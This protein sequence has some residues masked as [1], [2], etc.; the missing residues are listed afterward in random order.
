MKKIFVFLLI[1][2]FLVSGCTFNVDVLTPAPTVT[3]SGSSQLTPYTT[4]IAASPIATI[5][6]TAGP[7]STPPTATPTSPTFY[8]VFFKADPGIS[9]DG[10]T[11]PGGTKRVFAVWNYLNMRP[12][13]NVKREWYLNGQ[14][15]LTREEAWDFAKYDANGA[16]QDI[17]IYDF[18][19][20]L[21]TGI[22]E[23][24][25]YIDNVIQYIGTSDNGQP[26][27]KAR[28]EIRL[29]DEAQAGFASPDFQWQVEIF[30]ERRIVLEDKTRNPTTIYTAREVPY[31]S[32]F[33]DS[34]HFLFVDRDRS[35]QKPGTTIG[36]R[37]DLWVVDVP[38]GTT[39]LLYKSDTSFAGIGGP[40]PSPY[41]HYIA[42]LEGSRFGDA[43]SVDKRMIFFELSSDFSSA[44]VI[45][46][47]EFSGLPA[48]TNG[49]IYPN[50][51]VLVWYKDSTYIVTM[52]GTCDADKSKLGAYIFNLAD[53]TANKVISV[54]Q[55]PIPGDLGVGMIHGT[56]TDTTTGTP[57]LNATVTCEQHSYTSVTPCSGTV[58]T[59]A[60]GT[61]AF[62]NVFFH[63]TDTI[64]I[65]VEATGYQSQEFSRSAFTT[66]DFP[67]DIALSPKP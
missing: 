43:C 34:R 3:D 45:K 32:W 58:L 52:D 26:D 49:L 9:Q 28:F 11:F 66:N 24:R 6:A 35:G 38:S 65:K 10:M 21:P 56:I 39:H 50:E 17:S 15:W 67:L 48:F 29:K 40:T 51:Q 30:G 42:S 23:L 44:K 53:R 14:L 61:Y 7:V 5:S 25:L 4:Q 31:L 36:I 22:Y 60:D 55:Q 47:Q 63:D 46:Q 16:I 12:G 57:I 37:D 13:M 8:G 1:F 19:H 62:N 18:D 41:G 59:N 20:G 54:P 27:T 33:N 64:K 2:S